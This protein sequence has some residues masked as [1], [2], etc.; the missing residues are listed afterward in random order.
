MKYNKGRAEAGYWVG[1]G[2]DAVWIGPAPPPNTQQTTQTPLASDAASAVHGP[3]RTA[4]TPK[5][6]TPAPAA[7]SPHAAPFVPTPT[8]WAEQAIQPTPSPHHTQNSIHNT[9]HPHTLSLSTTPHDTTPKP[10]PN[11]NISMYMHHTHTNQHNT[12]Y[13]Y[14]FINPQTNPTP[15]HPDPIPTL[16]ICPSIQGHFNPDTQT[17]MNYPNPKTYEYVPQHLS[18]LSPILNAPPLPL[19]D[20]FTY[21]PPNHIINTL[22]NEMTILHDT[23]LQFTT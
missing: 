14:P 18:P 23:Y 15:K 8:K 13:P 2:A 6:A 5:K 16:H 11:P 4:S 20:T 10:S 1:A 21:H 19:N 12:L 9:L 7:L 22:P 3:P 17:Q